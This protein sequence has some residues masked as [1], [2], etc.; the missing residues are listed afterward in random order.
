[1]LHTFHQPEDKPP[2]RRAYYQAAGHCEQ[3][4]WRNCR[5]GE[6]LGCDGSHGEAKNQECTGVI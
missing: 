2:E 6:A 1:M 4:G 5:D 3:E